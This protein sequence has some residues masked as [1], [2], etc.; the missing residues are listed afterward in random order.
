MTSSHADALLSADELKAVPRCLWTFA[1]YLTI[2]ALGRG[3]GKKPMFSS[4]TSIFLVE[5]D[6]KKTLDAINVWVI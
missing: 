5:G 6:Q 2:M 4:L 3:G 1:L